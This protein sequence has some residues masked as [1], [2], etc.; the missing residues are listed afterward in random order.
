LFFM[1][2]FS[3]LLIK[4]LGLSTTSILSVHRHAMG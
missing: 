1:A 4:S 2:S 3:A